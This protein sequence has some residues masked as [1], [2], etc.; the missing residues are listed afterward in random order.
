[1]RSC[2]SS[3]AFTLPMFLT[4]Q[5]TGMLPPQVA[6]LGA[7]ASITVKSGDWI[8]IGTAIILLDSLDSL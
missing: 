7:V 1:M 5:D 3:R 4:S 6:S 8:L 2:Q